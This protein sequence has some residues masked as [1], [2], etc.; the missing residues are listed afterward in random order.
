MHRP[1]GEG[2]PCTQ[3]TVSRAIW[4]ELSVEKR[5]GSVEA[6]GVPWGHII[7]GHLDVLLKAEWSHF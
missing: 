5:E 4:L 6:G 3:R 7:S 1:G 2:E